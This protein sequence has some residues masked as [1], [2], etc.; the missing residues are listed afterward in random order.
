MVDHKDLKAATPEILGE[1]D[2]RVKSMWYAS[3]TKSGIELAD[4]LLTRIKQLQ[5]DMFVIPLRYSTL[6][7]HYGEWLSS[8]SYSSRD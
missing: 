7:Y 5:D 6:A 1:L 2:N 4:Q 8:C 3:N